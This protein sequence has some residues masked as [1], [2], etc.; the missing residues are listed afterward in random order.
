MTDEQE[1]AADETEPDTPAKWNRYQAIILDI[2]ER[3]YKGGEEFV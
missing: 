2:F 1:G 3:Y